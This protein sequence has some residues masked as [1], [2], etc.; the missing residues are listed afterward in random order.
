MKSLHLKLWQQAK[1]RVKK[2]NRSE[3]TAQSF[4]FRFNIKQFMFILMIYK[5]FINKACNDFH[6]HVTHASR[7]GS[8]RS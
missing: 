6:F 4:N 5:C 1:K 2:L 7:S 8:W 3:L